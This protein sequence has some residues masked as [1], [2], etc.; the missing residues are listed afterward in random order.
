[1]KCPKCNSNM[2]NGCCL[3]CGYMSN[4]NYVNKEEIKRNISDIE[5]FDKDY[6]KMN[7]NSN[8]YLPF[9]LGPFYLSY[10]GN[11]WL[12]FFLG[13]FD[14]LIRILSSL[15]TIPLVCMIIYF[16][17]SRLSYLIFANQLCIFLDKKKIS[18]IKSKYG[19]NYKEILNKHHNK[20]SYIFLT[21]IL[22]IFIVWLIF[23]FIKYKK[24]F[25]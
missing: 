1:M 17:I 12:G 24:Y 23:L 3:K 20:I 19:D 22:Y 5:L 13:I 4:G 15:T 2:M 7:R 9:M 16:I 18:K 11:F 25:M 10:K 6:D 21:I 14:Y 8:S